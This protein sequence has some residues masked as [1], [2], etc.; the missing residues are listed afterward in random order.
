VQCCDSK[1]KRHI[2]SLAFLCHAA[3][4]ELVEGIE[5]IMDDEPLDDDDGDDDDQACLYVNRNL[6]IYLC[7]DLSLCGFG[8]ASQ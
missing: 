8:M 1:F 2:Q 5:A 4:A 6:Y 7:F 3:E